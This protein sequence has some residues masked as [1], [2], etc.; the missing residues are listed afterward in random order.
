[1]KVWHKVAN[2][3]AWPFG[4]VLF[5]HS[6]LAA[7]HFLVYWPGPDLSSTK[8]LAWIT[9]YF[10]QF[11]ALYSPGPGEPC[12]CPPQSHQWLLI[13]VILKHKGPHQPVS[14]CLP[15]VHYASTSPTFSWSSNLPS[16][17]PLQGLCTHCPFSLAY[18][19]PLHCPVGSSNL[20][21][22]PSLT[23]S[24]HMVPRD[25]YIHL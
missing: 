17:S 5:L 10:F 20:L 14:F 24:C 19:P 25:I 4:P 13:A 18:A 6:Y 9:S 21:L 3:K 11:P 22:K 8:T 12:Y 16:L 15:L 7:S 2:S 23:P 1:M